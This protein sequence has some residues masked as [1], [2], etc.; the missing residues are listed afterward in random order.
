MLL[1][2]GKLSTGTNGTSTAFSGTISDSGG[3]TVTKVG[4]GIWTVSGTSTYS[5]AF[6]ASGG[7]VNFNSLPAL[8]AGS[9]ITVNS[10]TLQYASGTSTDISSRIVT[11]GPAGATIDTNGSNVTYANS[12]GNGGSGTFTKA[13]AGTLTLNALAG[14]KASTTVNGGT[15]QAGIANLL[16][17]ANDLTVITNGT[18][19]LNN[20]NQSIGSLAGAGNVTL[21]SA[22][23]T[24]GAGGNTNSTNFSGVISGSGIVHKMGASVL[25]LSGS[26]TYSG[27]TT[28][29]ESAQSAG[30]YGISV[31][32][33]ANLGNTAGNVTFTTPFGVLFTTGAA[34]NTSRLIFLGTTN[35]NFA[36]Y[37]N[38][39]AGT[40][41]TFSGAI[42]NLTG[43]P[44]PL[45]MA[46]TGTMVLNAANTF[47]AINGLTGFTID[48]GT[49]RLGIANA[50]PDVL[51]GESFGGAPVGATLDLN[52]FNQRVAGLGAGSAGTVLSTIT[53]TSATPVT[54][55]I[56]GPSEF[57]YTGK[58]TG[59]NLALVVNG[60]QSFNEGGGGGSSQ[61]TYGGGT[62]VLSGRLRTGY[63]T[64]SSS[65]TSSPFGLSFVGLNP[66]GLGSVTL[67]ALIGIGQCRTRPHQRWLDLQSHHHHC[68]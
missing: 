51:L 43:T 49:V 28:I 67:G 13:G 31:A 38:V 8:G 56:D 66:V 48:D 18:F 39:A 21:G 17:A 60:F 34:F 9:G 33:D 26:N 32:S 14:W 29:D 46:G 36:S 35:S 11:I 40:S 7:T 63:V 2:T 37:I 27:G 19:D 42:A 4:S 20:L 3:G 23:L 25:T 47:G 44:A 61:S 55:T 12:I 53:N 62:T 30:N 45:I 16:P 64:T 41:A 58:I 22:T 15:L 54:L 59:A 5:G 6:T 50:I 65:A 1:G 52:G 68:R 24:S 57:D 10:A